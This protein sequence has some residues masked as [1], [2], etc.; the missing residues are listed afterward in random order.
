MSSV[1]TSHSAEATSTGVKTP[2]DTSDLQTNGAAHMRVRS[3]QLVAGS[4]L[5]TASV[6]AA[7][8]L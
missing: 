1:D 5:F 8:L 6:V 4:T 3:F 7:L 2:S